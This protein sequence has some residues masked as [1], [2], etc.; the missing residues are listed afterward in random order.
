MH[1]IEGNSPS[2][3]ENTDSAHTLPRVLGPWQ[4]TAIVAGTIIGSGIFLVPR[5]MMRA[6]GSSNLVY[7]AWIAA[8][9]LSL[10]GAMTYAELAAMR[11]FAGGEYVYLRDAYGELPSFLYMWTWFSLAKPASIASSAI[12][13]VRVLGIFSLLTWLG[14]PLLLHP[15]RLEWGQIV[16][17]GVVWLIT[18]LNYLGL[19]RAGEFQLV[20]TLLKVALIAA[21]V[22]FCFNSSLGHRG[23]FATI[24]HGA[25]GGVAGFT[26]AMIA[27]LWAYDGWNDLN[28]VAGEIKRPGRSIPLALV[29]GVL[30]VALLYMLTNA[31]TGYLL[32]ATAIANSP[33]PTADAMFLAVGAWGA[34]LV[35]I[36]MAISILAS[37]NGTVLSGA[38]IPFA[39]ARDGIFFRA[40]AHI[41]PKFESPSVSLNVQAAMSTVLLLMVGRFQALFELALLGEWL[42]YMLTATTVFVFR[43]R[44]PDRERPYRVPLYPVLPG[45]FV[46]AALLVIT[47]IFLSNLHNSIGGLVVIA[48]GLPM[49]VW[50]RH[51]KQKNAA[52]DQ[53]L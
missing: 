24:F 28:M 33:R 42:F 23:N 21:I 40:M 19:R 14:R 53:L 36:G 3:D 39:A 37:L 11:P 8:G 2:H 35:S 44:E 9:I 27:A 17:I 29:A 22:Y 51:R 48:L 50:M 43:V 30:L 46:A 26:V 34:G 52:S 12:G 4:A 16:A 41:H 15:F 1:S 18:G 20:F 25:T 38:R 49:Y 13:L 32:P 47:Y 10:F 6:A 45:V 5:E 31:A 7:L